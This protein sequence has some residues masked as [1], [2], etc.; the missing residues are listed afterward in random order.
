MICVCHS[1]ALSLVSKYACTSI[2]THK[3][4]TQTVVVSMSNRQ[5][6]LPDEG[7]ATAETFWRLSVNEGRII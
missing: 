6:V 3:S 2:H 1:K 4:D 7:Q 5:S